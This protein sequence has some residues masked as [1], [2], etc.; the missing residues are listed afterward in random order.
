MNTVQRAIQLT[1][2]NGIRK[3]KVKNSK[4]SLVALKEMKN[5][6]EKIVN[7]KKNKRGSIF[8]TRKKEDLSA[9]YGTRGVVLTSEEAVLDH[10]GQASHWTP[11]VY[12][13]GTYSKNGLRTITGH[14]EKNLQQINCFVIDIDSKSFSM[15]RIND[16]ALNNGIGVPTM[17]LET[18]KGYQ[19]YYVLEQAV[20]VSKN[21]NY[22]AIQSAKRISQN[23]REMF[24]EHLPKVD[25]T[26]NHFGFFRMPSESNIVMFFEENVH[27]FKQLQEWSKRQDDNKG[28]EFLTSLSENNVIETHFS[29]NAPVEQP[30]QIDEYWF[31]QVIN[32]TNIMPK[33]TRAG[34]NNAI[35]TLSLA[36]FQS[37][38]K[39]QDTL[40]MMDQFNSYLE[41][42]L[43][44]SEVRGIVMSA[45][46]GKYRA[47]HNDYINRLLETYTNTKEFN[48]GNVPS[49]LWRK[50]KK[51]REDRVRS[52]W[53]EWEADIITF[54]SMNAKNKPVLY[55]SQAELC[56]A[57][58]IPRSTLN[59]VL[60]KSQKIYKT[61][62]G[63]GKHAKTGLS[64]I[65]MLISFA[66]LEKS[67]KRTSYISFLEKVFP[68]MGSIISKFTSSSTTAE[69]QAAHSI[70][71]GLPAG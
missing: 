66:L 46:S 27:S 37:K 19:V 5:L 30:Q 64:T 6:D 45:Y 21:K 35:F 51:K 22:I 8:I 55:F 61:V 18:A 9:D 13:F 39:I 17:I 60:K 62:E 42:P 31:K 33:Q 56:Q 28:K 25:L 47:A 53:H 20:Y 32:C 2:H 49:M 67:R 65:G 34:R 1:L 52:H 70:F 7:G 54:L 38:V 16:V 29:K 71:E 43:D 59:T 3:Y 26:C 58:S 41:L 69:K 40:N 48:Q 36:C 12:N 50:H 68:Q 14:A 4:A 63:K 23:L 57:L 24:A 10:V 15:T 44:H 11:N